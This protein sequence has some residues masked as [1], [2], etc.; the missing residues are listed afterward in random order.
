LCGTKFQGWL[1]DRSGA[2]GSTLFDIHEEPEIFVRYI[3]HYAA[4]GREDLGFD[5][6][7]R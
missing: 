7:I 2:K 3:C 4:M 5:P 1:F 6:I